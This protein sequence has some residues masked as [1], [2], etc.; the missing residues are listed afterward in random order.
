VLAVEAGA[1][2]A[3]VVVSE[4]HH[5]W[6]RADVDGTAIDVRRADVGLMAVPVPPGAHEVRLAFGPP[7]IVRIADA[8]DRIAWVVC[9]AWLLWLAA[10]VARRRRRAAGSS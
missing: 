1:D 10:T 4:S 8:T 7:A 3:Y 9:G 2:P 6:W 5:P